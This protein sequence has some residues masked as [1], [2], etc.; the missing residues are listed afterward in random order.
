MQLVFPMTIAALTLLLVFVSSVLQRR[1]RPHC[2]EPV[3]PGRES[4]GLFTS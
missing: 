2:Y 1:S 4:T 3:E